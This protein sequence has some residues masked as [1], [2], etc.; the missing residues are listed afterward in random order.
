MRGSLARFVALVS[1]VRNTVPRVVAANITTDGLTLYVVFNEP[2]TEE[3]PGGFVIDPSGG[4]TTLTYDSGTGTT[5]LAYTLGR[6]I[7]YNETATLEFDS[8]NG[9]VEDLSG[10]DLATFSGFG[11]TNNSE[12]NEPIGSFT[13]LRPGGIDRYKRPGGVDSYIRP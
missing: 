10:N 5:T 4:S 7:E 8:G 3:T 6:E 9:D 13:Y 11:V 12:V 2:V 1:G